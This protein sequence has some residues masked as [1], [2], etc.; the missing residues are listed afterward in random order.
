MSEYFLSRISRDRKSFLNSITQSFPASYNIIFS[1]QQFACKQP[2]D[3]FAPRYFTFD[4]F[5]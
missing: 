4:E 2:F 5:A 3:W 1:L